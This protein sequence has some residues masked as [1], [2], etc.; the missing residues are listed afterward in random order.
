MVIDIVVATG[1]VGRDFDKLRLRRAC[2]LG[3]RQNAK[4]DSGKGFPRQNSG[5]LM[6]LDSN[7]RTHSVF[8]S[9]DQEHRVR[10]FARGLSIAFISHAIHDRR[11]RGRM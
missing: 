2:W 5:A 7:S 1:S 3:Y 4:V 9:A 10:A 6:P 11:Q 8:S